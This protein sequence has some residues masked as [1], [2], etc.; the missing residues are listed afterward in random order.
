MAEDTEKEDGGKGKGHKHDY[1]KAAEAL[2]LRDNSKL[3]EL[4]TGILA[5]LATETATPAMVALGFS[6]ATGGIG[7]V[8]TALA[9]KLVSKKFETWLK[10][11]DATAKFSEKVAETQSEADRR[12]LL[13]DI[14]L[15]LVPTLDHVTSELSLHSVALAELKQDHEALFNAILR[16]LP[17]PPVDTLAGV[18]RARTLS[19]PSLPG[20][21]SPAQLLD[22]RYRVVP[23]DE[24]VRARELAE[25]R[26]FCDDSALERLEVR[27]FYGAGGVG[28]SRLLMHFCEELWARTTEV[29]HAGFLEEREQ[30]AALTALAAR[31]YPALVI[32]DYA[33]GRK[34]HAW[35][36]SLREAEPARTKLRI[37]LLA[38]HADEWWT[39]LAEGDAVIEHLRRLPAV[40]LEG[41]AY[42]PGDRARMYDKAR[43]AYAR[44]LHR[45][46]PSTIS[47]GLQEAHFAR[48][49][50]IQMAALFDVI[51]SEPRM[52]SPTGLPWFF[53]QREHRL[54]RSGQLNENNSSEDWRMLRLVAA[55]TLLGGV[56]LEMLDVL[57]IASKCAL[58]D[59]LIGRLMSFYPREQGVG[60]LEPDLLGEALV[61]EVLLHKQ[62]RTAFLDKVLAEASPWQV[63]QALTVL[64]RI[65]VDLPTEARTWIAQALRSKTLERATPA[66][67]AA[68]AVA[69]SQVDDVLGQELA[70]ALKNQPAIDL[71][72]LWENRLPKRTV[73]L[74]EL[75]VWAYEQLKAAARD[76]EEAARCARLLGIAYSEMGRRED[77]LAAAEEA[78]GIYRKMAQ[79]RP[80][81]V[82]PDLAASL[83]NL[84]I[85][86]SSLGRR[87]DAVAAAEEAAGICR[88]MA[89][90]RPDAFLADLARSLNNLGT[91]YSSL[92]RREDAL[93]ASEE[94][95]DIRRKLAQARPDAFL[96]DLARSLNNLGIRYSSLGRREDA[97]SVNEEAAGI[98]RKLA[99]SRPDAFLADL[100]ASLNNLGAMYSSV[101]RREDALSAS[102]EA[103]NI[104][105]RLAQ[106]RPDAFLTDL[107]NG[108]NNLGIWYSLL[109][110]RDDALSATEEAVDICRKLA[111][112]RP[113]AFLADLAR[114]LNNLGSNYKE[115]GRCEDA[116]SVTEESADIYRKLAQ[117]RPDAFLADLAASLNNLGGDYSS[118]GRCEQSVS[119]TEEAVDIRRRLARAHPDA[120]LAD[121]A[122]S[123]T[124]LG[125]NYS[126]LGRCEEALSATIESADIY[127]KLAQARPDAFLADLAASLSNLGGDY[128]SLGRWE[129][130]VSATEEAIDIRDR[131]ALEQPDAFL[132]GLASNLANLGI[133][134][135]EL[136]RHKEALSATEK[137]AGIYRKL[138]QARPDAF[139]AADLARSLGNLGA[140]Y[141]SLGRRED[142]L[143]ASAESA[144]IYRKLVERWPHMR[145]AFNLS[146]Q[147]VARIR[148]E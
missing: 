81:A 58:D 84:G 111:Q 5:T 59:A 31:G 105:R 38:R 116:L 136:G 66:F 45:G 63:Q 4:L 26:A 21:R 35:L 16:R 7:G 87:E 43:Q 71:A 52:Q 117:A 28:K 60:S 13:R 137:S 19:L 10:E 76:E 127:R 91:R 57:A 15:W 129:E 41:V 34:L 114:S 11:N 29:W 12:V 95:V 70:A 64:G 103:V 123:L 133:W 40:R 148:S 89:H 53:V 96:A 90:S 6:A 75:K 18:L 77:A 55:V 73:S 37:V 33:E 51:G 69:E 68:L 147:L 112:A 80:D 124:N 65:A 134:Y 61:S 47:L 20:D 25:L 2:A 107:A 98:Y 106:A 8:A 14:Q 120:F 48:P 110:R 50:Y 93:A 17:D 78:A 54:W 49:L 139:L 1:E 119:A 115:L 44:A 92:G 88:K 109:G 140:I 97:L 142:A 102:G 30:N 125:S 67:E 72:R 94:A 83:N 42:A 27:L 143:S 128:S 22:A 113:D 144:G 36:K 138:A 85:L 145:V 74:R 46:T 100:A 79:T 122:S 135:R 121:L 131:L 146:M 108:L 39:N 23:F 126:E 118:L 24:D 82:L 9:V 99:H 3:R 62:T 104:R 130:A 141:S 132:P 101:G 32:I 86:Y 56:T